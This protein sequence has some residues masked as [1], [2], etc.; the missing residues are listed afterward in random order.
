MNI[1]LSWI[2]TLPYPPLTPTTLFVVLCMCLMY[3]LASQCAPTPDA[4]SLSHYSNAYHP[5]RERTVYTQL[6]HGVKNA[7]FGNVVLP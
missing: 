6:L 5:T 4:P 1:N 7:G 3:A 2:G